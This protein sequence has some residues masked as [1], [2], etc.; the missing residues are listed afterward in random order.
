MGVCRIFLSCYFCSFSFLLASQVGLLSL[1]VHPYQHV[2]QDYHQHDRDHHEPDVEVPLFRCEF[3]QHVDE[4]RDVQ[5]NVQTLCG[6]H[7]LV[8]PADAVRWVGQRQEEVHRLLDEQQDQHHRHLFV[9]RQ[10]QDAH[11]HVFYHKDQVEVPLEAVGY[12]HF[13]FQPEPTRLVFQ[14]LGFQQREPAQRLSESRHGIPHVQ[15]DGNQHHRKQRS[16]HDRQV[17]NCDCFVVDVVSEG[18]V[19]DDREDDVEVEGFDDAEE[20]LG[21]DGG[22]EFW[23]RRVCYFER[24][25]LTDRPC[26]LRRRSPS[27]PART[28]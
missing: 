16:H 22:V 2:H 24:R 9:H 4:E 12:L 7:D 18:D 5:Q 6:E 25:V 11:V 15:V 1:V 26:A 3:G 10:Q 19:D 8:V 21:S 27:D 14:V 28:D 13:V 17:P 23:V 20:D